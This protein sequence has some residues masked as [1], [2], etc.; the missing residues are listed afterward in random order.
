MEDSPVLALRSQTSLSESEA[1][2]N[3]E[4]ARA[5]L[6]GGRLDSFDILKFSLIV[7]PREH[8]QTKEMNNHGYTFNFLCLCLPGPLLGDPGAVRILYLAVISLK[9][10]LHVSYHITC[11][12]IGN[13]FRFL[14]HLNSRKNR[15]SNL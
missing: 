4:R 6:R 10:I 2:H 12:R 5:G 15:F 8:K 13:A 1:F 3:R 11:M 9:N 7:R 14:F